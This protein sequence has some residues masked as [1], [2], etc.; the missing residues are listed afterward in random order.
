MFFKRE[1]KYND[2]ATDEKEYYRQYKIAIIS[3]GLSISN[4]ITPCIQAMPIA[5]TI[6]APVK[7]PSVD[8]FMPA[9]LIGY[10]QY[11]PVRKG[12]QNPAYLPLRGH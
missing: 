9:S 7:I 4:R 1:F 10:R 3:V 8:L 2:R 12:L 11:I 5:E 6:T